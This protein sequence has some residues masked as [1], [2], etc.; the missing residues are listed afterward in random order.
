M[1]ISQLRHKK[2]FF[3]NVLKKKIGIKEEKL[4]LKKA[5]ILLKV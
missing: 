2:Y 3:L 5:Q 1:F 4:E